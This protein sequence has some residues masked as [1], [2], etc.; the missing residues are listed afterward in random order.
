MGCVSNVPESVRA[1]K[2]SVSEQ[3]KFSPGWFDLGLEL[4]LLGH[5]DKAIYA[6]SRAV[7]LEP[8]SSFARRERL[9]CAV[10]LGQAEL[11]EKDLGQMPELASTT[12]KTQGTL[13]A[14][15]CVSL[16]ALARNFGQK[17]I[18]ELLKKFVPS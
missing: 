2:K 4:R 17:A 3:P 15:A 13:P 1:F 18:E 12:V 9:I 8:K 16:S 5:F 11:V 14:E 6:F 7:T 10:V